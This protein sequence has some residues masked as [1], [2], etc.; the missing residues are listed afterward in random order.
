MKGSPL[1]AAA[2][3]AVLAGQASATSVE[4]TITPANIKKQTNP[5]LA[6]TVNDADG[7]KRFEVAVKGKAGEEARFLQWA[8]L[9][10]KKNGRTVVI[11]P[12]ARTE[13]KGDVVFSFTVSADH[14]GGSTFK[15]ADIA[16]FKEKD[17]RGQQKWV[18]MPSANFLTF[19]LK[20]F[21]RADKGKEK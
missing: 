20:E 9:T 13:R 3:L 17:E 5:A 21:A 8:T 4:T 16:H 14:L 18:G 2:L 10:V 6:V 1:L 7:L 11:C 19:P 12:V 15:V